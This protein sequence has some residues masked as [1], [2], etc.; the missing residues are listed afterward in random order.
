MRSVVSWDVWSMRPN[1][2]LTDVINLSVEFSTSAHD[3]ESTICP[4]PATV[5]SSRPDMLAIFFVASSAV[6]TSC[7]F[8]VVSIFFNSSAYAICVFR[9][10]RIV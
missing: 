8:C 1:S 2:P 5:L 3:L 9:V 7:S 6:A 4:R 10:S